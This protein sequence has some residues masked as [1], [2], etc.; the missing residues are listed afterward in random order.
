[1]VYPKGDLL[2]HNEPAEPIPG[3]RF[4]DIGAMVVGVHVGRR[5]VPPEDLPLMVALAKQ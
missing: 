5:T 3:R 4:E 2:F 1:L